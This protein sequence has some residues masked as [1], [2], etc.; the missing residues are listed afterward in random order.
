MTL[1]VKSCRNVWM[2]RNSQLTLLEAVSSL[3]QNT[4]TL[5]FFT[6]KDPWDPT[7]ISFQQY[8]VILFHFQFLQ[9]AFKKSV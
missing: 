9:S 8:R 3:K 5:W 4:E 1:A 2:T 6:L 7:A